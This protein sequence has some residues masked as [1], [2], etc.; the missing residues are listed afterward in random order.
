MFTYQPLYVADRFVSSVL[1]LSCVSSFAS[2]LVEKKQTITDKKIVS[3][4][5]FIGRKSTFFGN[6]TKGALRFS[7]VLQK[8]TFKCTYK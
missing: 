3:S 2:S 8:F 5:K 6:L 4:G 1:P 7:L